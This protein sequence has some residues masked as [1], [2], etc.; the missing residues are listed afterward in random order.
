MRSQTLWMLASGLLGFSFFLIANLTDAF[1]GLNV[2][3]GFIQL[4]LNAFVFVTWLRGYRTSSGFR[5]FVA[6]WGIVVPIVMATITI[7]RVILP[8]AIDLFV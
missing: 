4:V 1:A 7:L 8:A 5:K 2:G 6:F 3:A